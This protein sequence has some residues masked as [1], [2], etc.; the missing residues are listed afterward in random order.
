MPSM[1][2]GL[3]Q[4]SRSLPFAIV[5]RHHA[6]ARGERP[7]HLRLDEVGVELE[8]IDVDVGEAGVVRDRLG[9]HVLVD[10][11]AGAALAGEGEPVDQVVG[12][13]ALLE[14]GARPGLGQ[15][16]SLVAEL[17][18][19]LLADLALA[20]EH[21]GDEVGTQGRHRNE[22]L[23]TPA[24]G[25]AEDCSRSARLRPRARNRLAIIR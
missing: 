3:A 10:H 8:R 22:I 14:G 21:L 1:S 9:D 11:G 16:A 2:K 17:G 24:S 6:V 18:C 4:A 5:E 20:L 7:R 15:H 13:G 12:G 19:L 25:R 23:P